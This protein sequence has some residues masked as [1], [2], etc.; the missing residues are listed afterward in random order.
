LRLVR[1]LASGERRLRVTH[2]ARYVERETA[3]VVGR[4][5]GAAPELGE[6]IVGAHY[7]TQ[8]E[9]PGASDNATGLAALLEL[10]RLFGPRRPP[11][12]LTFVAFAAE[13]LAAWGAYAYV[14]EH[15]GDPARMVAMVNLDALGAPL[16]ATRTLVVDRSL[17]AL[18]TECARRVGWDVEVTVE[19]GE[20]PYADHIPF[21]DAGVPACWLWRYPPNHPYYH[22]AGDVLR[23]VDVARLAHDTSA[24]AAVVERLVSGDFDPGPA[25][26]T[27][28]SAELARLAA[29]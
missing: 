5:P 6:V 2:R 29:A 1:A 21:V 14:V 23:H 8:L 9:G 20:F 16:D 13:E 25:R 7:D 27:E 4:I 18:A 10:A 15:L 28:R 22:S 12:G 11:R 3:N 17:A 26:P 24:A 19:A